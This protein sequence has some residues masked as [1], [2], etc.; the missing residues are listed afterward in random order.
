MNRELIKEMDDLKMKARKLGT[1]I[2]MRISCSDGDSWVDVP[3]DS[4][5][6]YLYPMGSHLDRY[7][8]KP[9]ILKSTKGDKVNGKHQKKHHVKRICRTCKY[10]SV[11][12]NAHKTTTYC[13]QWESRDE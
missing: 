10:W 7:R 3:M 6:L 12:A 1:T 11:C 13:N 4:G 8:I 9:E 5:Q 2:Q